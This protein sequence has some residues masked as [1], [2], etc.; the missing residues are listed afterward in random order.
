MTDLTV[1]NEN[2]SNLGLIFVK[3]R[4][5]FTAVKVTP[6]TAGSHQHEGP[7]PEPGV[8]VHCILKVHTVTFQVLCLKRPQHY[9][10]TTLSQ[11]FL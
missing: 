1:N 9:H 8:R 7:S 2:Q 4:S 5:I 6:E 10:Y 3:V 11:K